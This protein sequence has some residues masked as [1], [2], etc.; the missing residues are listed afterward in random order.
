MSP[1]TSSF[2]LD[3]RCYPA[4]PGCYLLEDASGQVLYVGKAVNLRKR[5]SSYFRPRDRRTASLA[6]RVAQVEV[7][8][9]R[10]ELE[11]LILENNL[12]K[13]HQ[14]AYNRLLKGED[15]GYY[16]IV[17]TAEELPR[18]APYRRGRFN[19]ELDGAPIAQSFGPYAGRD[20]RDRL[21][22]LAV[23]AFRLRTC[24]AQPAK[25]CLRYH[26]HKCSGICEARTS[27]PDYAAAVRGAAAF[28]SRPQPALVN[29]MRQEMLAH[30]ER[31]EFE[32]AQRLKER[33][34]ALEQ[35]LSPQVVE[36]QVDHDEDVIYFGS[37][38]ALVA[39]VRR[40][41]L[42]GLSLCTLQPGNGR[43]PP[44]AGFLL[45]RYAAHA[46][47]EIIVNHLPD[48]EA[49]EQALRQATGRRVRITIPRRGAKAALL[50]L[51]AQNYDY[52]TSLPK[53]GSEL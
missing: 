27:R 43:Q 10:S 5:L 17:L 22:Q 20:Y 19:E 52:R 1:D 44:G 14:P 36:R 3:L 38:E 34:E 35:A 18:L 29:T 16:Y 46:P 33:I 9:V 28:L 2:G 4:G 13:L 11:S 42:Q 7:I 23:E 6:A 48:R 24:R 12:I 32:C 47:E 25:A 50:A 49:V 30:A 15:T 51:C 45:S 26:M 21:L 37:D 41:V 39:T 8:L 31:L 53:R 40:G